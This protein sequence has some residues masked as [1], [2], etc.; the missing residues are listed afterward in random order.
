MFFL[1]HFIKTHHVLSLTPSPI[2]IDSPETGTRRCRGNTLRTTTRRGGPAALMP[3]APSRGTGKV[4]SM[5]FIQWFLKHSYLY[6]YSTFLFPNPATC[7]FP[8][9]LVVTSLSHGPLTGRRGAKD[10]LES[11]SNRVFRKHFC[12]HGQ[13]W[14]MTSAYRH[15]CSPE[16]PVWKKSA[17]HGVASKQHEHASACPHTPSWQ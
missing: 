9:D 7:L 10:F 2:C 3:A 14:V 16:P 4:V 1:L 11:H 13:H 8:T 17:M 5:L 15:R 12:A 6:F